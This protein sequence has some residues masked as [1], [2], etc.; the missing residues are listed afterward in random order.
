MVFRDIIDFHLSKYPYSISAYQRN[1]SIHDAV[2]HIV[3]YQY[4]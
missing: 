2:T 4:C 3:Q 1:I